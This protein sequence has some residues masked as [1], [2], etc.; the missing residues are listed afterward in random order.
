MVRHCTRVHSSMVVL[1]N[2]DANNCAPK[3]CIREKKEWILFIIFTGCNN[4]L[5]YGFVLGNVNHFGHWLQLLC[6]IVV[7]RVSVGHHPSIPP[8]V[9]PSLPPS[10]LPSVHPST[11]V[12]LHRAAVC[13][14]RLACAM[15]V[16]HMWG[17]L[18]NCLSVYR[19]LQGWMLISDPSD[20]PGA[21]VTSSAK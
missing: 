10:L 8:S 11:V 16:V 12:E 5:K 18:I 21:G 7:L 1:T 17:I 14:N 13:P 2:N 15:V 19:W 4:S 6:P 20:L 9:R 3:S